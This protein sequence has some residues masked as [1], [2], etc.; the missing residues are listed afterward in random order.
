MNNPRDIAEDGQQDIQ[1]ELRPDT[2]LKENSEGREENSEN[3]SNEIH[4]VTC[5]RLCRA[6]VYRGPA[7]AVYS[8]EHGQ[9][10]LPLR[11]P[12]LPYSFRL[13]ERTF[14]PFA[15]GG[16]KNSE[17]PLS[18]VAR[19]QAFYDNT[20]GP[21]PGSRFANETVLAQDRYYP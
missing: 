14:L 15:I 8:R 10:A 12:G 20:I 2:H 17:T 11:V 13:A 4:A 21:P 9:R 6:V 19:D 5:C 3:D 7:K 1:P 16:E 18:Q